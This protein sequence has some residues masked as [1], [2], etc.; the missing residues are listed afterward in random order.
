MEP[1]PLP[2]T[3]DREDLDSKF[4]FSDEDPTWPEPPIPMAEVMEEL[5]SPGIPTLTSER[6]TRPI[7]PSAR[8]RMEDRA[9]AGTEGLGDGGEAR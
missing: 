2:P 6:P 1:E 4:D 9:M 5:R 7:R 3:P 8:W